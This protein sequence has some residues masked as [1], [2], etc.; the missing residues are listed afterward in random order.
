VPEVK[1]KQ[2]GSASFTSRVLAGSLARCAAASA[3]RPFMPRGVAAS[4]SHSTPRRR[5]MRGSALRSAGTQPSP[6]TSRRGEISSMPWRST[7]PR[8]LGFSMPAT[9]PILATAATQASME[10]QFS[11]RIATVSPRRAPAAR[12]ARAMRLAQALNAW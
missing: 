4:P 6:T 7:A 10:G 1:M 12:R 2:K 5:G 9:A 3:R 8:W 11:D